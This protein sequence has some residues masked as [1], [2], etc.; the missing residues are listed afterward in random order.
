MNPLKNYLT[1]G[2]KY[3]IN[4]FIHDAYKKRKVYFLRLEIN[5][6][7]VNI[8]FSILSSLNIINL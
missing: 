4:V 3:K 7:E 6:L 2:W 1:L 8:F 5:H